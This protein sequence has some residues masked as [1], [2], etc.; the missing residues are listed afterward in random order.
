M[1]S[2]INTKLNNYSA[3]KRRWSEKCFYFLLRF[4]GIGL[5]L[6]IVGVVLSLMVPAIFTFQNLSW[7]FFLSTDWNPVTNQFGALNA[8]YGTIMTAII[9]LCLAV[10]VSIG[11]AIFVTQIAP[12]WLRSPMAV[13]LDVMAG[14]P[15]I[16]FGMWGLFIL[17]PILGQNVYPF[18]NQVFSFIPGFS[19]LFSGS[20]LGLGVFTAG[21]VLSLMIIPIVSSLVVNLIQMSDVTIKEAGYGLG[22]N[23][24]EVIFGVILPSIKKG[25]V[26]SVILGF[27]RAL[28]ETM[29]VTFVI[30]NIQ[31]ISIELFNPGTSIASS[32]ANE[33]SESINPL[34]T[35]SLLTLGL[36]LFAM[37][38]VCLAC[39]RLLLQDF[40]R[41]N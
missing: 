27:G 31:R 3:L 24:F 22:G 39:S 41:R 21:I 7:S 12:K 23:R 20:F 37:T 30:G 32:I 13:T 10:P 34:Q 35:S 15:S 19:T 14:I 1:E 38:I 26:G 40:K 4:L 16:V 29:A 6:I 18:L 2:S 8:I 33:V 9:A 11:V 17:A 36:I 25:L 5:L 28:G